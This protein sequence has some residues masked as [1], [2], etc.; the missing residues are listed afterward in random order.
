MKR[1]LSAIALLALGGCV[2]PTYPGYGYYGGGYGGPYY[3]GYGGPYYAG[4]A[5]TYPYG[6]YYPPA[7][8]FAPPIYGSVFF[9]SGFHNHNQGHFFVGPN[10]RAFV[11]P[12]GGVV[13]GP[14]GSGF[15]GHPGGL[16][17]NPNFP[18]RNGWTGYRSF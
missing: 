7:A 18:N 16:G 12:N 5:G 15:V 17:F 4:Y 9:G 13:V 3:A 14:R 10:R 11:G 6:G 1:L 8:F 2:Y